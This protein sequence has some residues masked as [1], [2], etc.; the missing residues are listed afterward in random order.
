MSFLDETATITLTAPAASDGRGEIAQLNGADT[1]TH[2]VG[3]VLSSS[4]SVVIRQSKDDISE[5]HG[6]VYGGQWYGDATHTLEVMLAPASTWAASYTRR[7]KLLAATNAMAAD[8]TM[9][10]TDSGGAA[11]LINFRR[12]QYPSGPD[13]DRK[14]LLVL[15]SSDPRIYLNTAQTGSS[16]KTNTGK[17]GSPPTFTFSPTTTGTVILTN[18]TAG[19][20]SPAV[21]L[22]VATGYLTSGGGAVTVDFGAKTVTQGGTHKEGAVVFPGSTWWEV[23]PGANTWTITGTATVTGSSISFR[24][25]W[26]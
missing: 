18:T 10:W 22:T 26:V 16:P 17:V 1:D 3:R 2:F 23:I 14:M 5:G 6:V 13:S 11:R 15:A 12:E 21:T 8:G 20:G 9:V 4:R 7:E 24:D 25:A 19:Y